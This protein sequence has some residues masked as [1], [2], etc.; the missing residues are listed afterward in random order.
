MRTRA[1][2]GLLLLLA[3]CGGSPAPMALPP[4][5]TLEV[6]DFRGTWTGTW[7]GSAVTLVITEQE[8]QDW[9]SGVYVGSMQVLGHRVPGVGG[10]LTSGVPGGRVSATVRG[11]M[12]AS[13]R[14]GVTLLLEAR[15]VDGLQHLTLASGPP[16]RLAGQGDSEFRWGPRGPIVLMRSSP[17]RTGAKT[18]S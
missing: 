14:G 1:L 9:R 15:T 10:V 3:G 7:G 18:G 6:P 8:D 17:P 16:D 12:M 13:G 2:L 4:G 11:W 5:A